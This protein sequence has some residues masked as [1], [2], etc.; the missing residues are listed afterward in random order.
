M[1]R[2]KALA[3]DVERWMAD[4]PVTAWREPSLARA[5][6]WARRNR[7]AVTAA[8]V[9]LVAGVVGLGTVAAV[10]ARANSQLR[11][12]NGATNQALAE[13]RSA[14]AETQAALATVGGISQTGR[15]GERVPGARRSAAPTHRETDGTSRWPTYWTAS[16]RLDKEFI[17]SQATQ[18]ALLDA[19][20][21]TYQGLGL[22]DRAVRLHTRARAVREVALGP[23]HLHTL[24]SRNNLANAYGSAGPD[25]RG[26]RTARGDAQAPRV[27]AR[28]RPRRHAQCRNN[29]ASDY[30]SA[31][32]TAEAITLHKGTLKLR[33]AKLGPDHPDTLTSRQNLAI[34]YVAAGR[35]PRRLPCSRR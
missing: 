25:C 4:E 34:A 8:A 13:T 15:G 18:G 16:E 29:L 31:G 24:A 3:E 17:G 33:E 14:Q 2:A 21:R 10:Q 12:A 9:A 7:T 26:D 27:K 1:P 23:D 19:L 28:P 6:R 30:W 22:Y 20:G 32:Q 35:R 5:R 11:L